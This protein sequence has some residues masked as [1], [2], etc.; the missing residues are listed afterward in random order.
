M[1]LFAYS[2]IQIKICWD[3]QLQKTNSVRGWCY[4]RAP[5][6]D[7]DFTATALPYGNEVL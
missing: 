1:E 2:G 7:V 3:G 4:S 6:Y 5:S